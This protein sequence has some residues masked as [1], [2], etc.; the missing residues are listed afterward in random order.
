MG[1]AISF[2]GT[3]VLC[4]LIAFG[5]LAATAFEPSPGLLKW[6]RER[7]GENGVSRV[8]DW[9]K[10]E[11]NISKD[12]V[13][14]ANADKNLHIA[15]SPFSQ[16]N[17]F[18]NRIPFVSPNRYWGGENYWATPVE[19]LGSNTAFCVHYAT[20]KY[21]SLQDVRIPTE[22][23]RIT[24]VRAKNQN[25]W[26]MVLAYYPNPDSDPYILDN[27]IGEIKPAS[28]RPDLIPVYSF[29]DDDMWLGDGSKRGS[30]TQ[31]RQW[32]ELKEKLNKEKNL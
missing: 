16:V 24:Y 7:W 22:K 18:F 6:V 15:N 10:L 9:L 5:A 32:K 31:V 27:L 1:R 30:S 17:A 29:N 20:S 8:T 21:L 4:L 26:H 13:S 14:S 11:Q 12:G 2:F 19:A 28:Q 23:M 3:L 25:E